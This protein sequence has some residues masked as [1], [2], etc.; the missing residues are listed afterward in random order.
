MAEQKLIIGYQTA[1]DFWRAARV[2]SSDLQEPE[3]VGRTYGRLP[4]DV[5]SRTRRAI[6]L[7][8]AAAP[9]DVVAPKRSERARNPLVTPHSCSAPMSSP[10][11]FYIDDDVAVCR[12][13]VV[14]VQLA[15]GASLVDLARI[16]YEMTGSYGF[17]AAGELVKD[18]RPLVDLGELRGYALSGRAMRVRGATRACR[19]LELV[20]PNSNSPR[21]TDVAISLMMPRSMGGFFMPGF[22]MNQPIKLSG[23]LA[24]IVGT[25]TLTPDFYWPDKKMI[26]EYESD[27]FH[28]SAQAIGR[29]ERRRRAFEREGYHVM[30]LMNDDLMANDRLNSFMTQLAEG[31][32][33]RRRPASEAMLGR[34]RE[35]REMLFGPV[36]KEVAD[37]ERE[38]P[39]EG[40]VL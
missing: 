1:L 40:V 17:D 22:A 7:L 35:L 2:A 37:W 19:A 15:Y 31:M 39:Y 38:H 32:G 9:I 30:R 12:M 11:L 13:P 33:L 10:N 6:E 29:D 16:A 20:A 34:R 23:Q 5:G 18:L 4:Q 36:S 26:V 25:D 3:A 24:A 27:E 21:E 28:A 14:L 8:G